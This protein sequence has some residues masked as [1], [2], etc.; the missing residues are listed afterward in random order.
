MFKKI[1]DYISLQRRIQIEIL[2]TLC[3]ICLWL[4]RDGHYCRNPYSQYM[5][6]HFRVLK[7]LSKEL[8]DYENH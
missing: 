5:D 6:G 7:D 2:E 3:T 1:K 4:E 8:I